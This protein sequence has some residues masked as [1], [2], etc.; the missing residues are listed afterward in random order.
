MSHGRCG[1]ILRANDVLTSVR[2]IHGSGQARE[3]TQ[4]AERLLSG[5]QGI[6]AIASSKPALRLPERPQ[7]F[8]YRPPTKRISEPQRSHI[9]SGANDAPRISPVVMS[10]VIW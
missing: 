3:V 2:R 10:F 6:S 5:L 4:R 1:K 9:V 8:L 7:N